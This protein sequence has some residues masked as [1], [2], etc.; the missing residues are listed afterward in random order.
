MLM[1]LPHLHNLLAN[2]LQLH[3]HVQFELAK[4]RAVM[5]RPQGTIAPGSD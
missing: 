2:N 1:I 3:G 4:C 5:V